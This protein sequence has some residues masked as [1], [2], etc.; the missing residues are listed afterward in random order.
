MA[1][2][3]LTT[4]WNNVAEHR[5]MS[6]FTSKFEMISLLVALRRGS[7]CR[8]SAPLPVIWES[9][10]L[11][12][13]MHIASCSPRV[14]FAQSRVVAT[15]RASFPKPRFWLRLRRIPIEMLLQRA[16]AFMAPMD[17]LNN[18]PRFLLPPWKLHASGKVLCGRRWRP[19][20]SAKSS[21][22]H[23]RKAPLGCGMQLRI[24]FAGRGA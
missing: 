18:S 20:M 7:T 22:P 2:S 5:S 10:S 17:S 8:L 1:N 13:K 15:T 9:V 23:L 11:R 3:C 6:M 21:R 12:S 4:I 24:I 19:K 14:I 16:L